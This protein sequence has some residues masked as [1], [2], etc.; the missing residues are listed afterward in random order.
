MKDDPFSG[1]H[2]LGFLF[3]GNIDLGLSK[4]G[5]LFWFA[6]DEIFF[7]GTRLLRCSNEATVNCQLGFRL[8]NSV[9]IRILGGE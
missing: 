2:D 5:V 8:A 7:S 1:N 4:L 6:R 3:W 9:E